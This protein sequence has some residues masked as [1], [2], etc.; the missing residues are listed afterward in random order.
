MSI[1]AFSAL[2]VAALCAMAGS[3]A[4]FAGGQRLA[5]VSITKESLH[6]TAVKVTARFAADE[7]GSVRGFSF[8]DEHAGIKGLSARVTELRTFDRY[9]SEIPNRRG[10]GGTV[11]A[12]APVYAVTYAV[13]IETRSD[14]TLGAH[15]SWFACGDGALMMYDLLPVSK[16]AGPPVKVTIDTARSAL[17]ISSVYTPEK[18]GAFLVTDVDN[19]VFVL[20]ATARNLSASAEGADLSFSVIGSWQYTDEDLVSMTREILAEYKRIFGLVPFR[21]IHLSIM[22]IGC[23]DLRDRWRAETRGPS[24]L[25]LSSPSTYRNHGAQL[26]HEQLR[27]ELLHLWIPNALRL[28]GDYSWFY[29]GFTF[30]RALIAGASLGRIRFEDVL[31]ALADSYR[32]AGSSGRWY[33]VGESGGIPLSSPG[34]VQYSQAVLL[35]FAADVAMMDGSGKNVDD[36]LRKVFREGTRLPV[37]EDAGE[38][39]I[40][41][42]AEYGPLI[43]IIGNHIRGTLPP[44]WAAFFQKAGL[45]K[46]PAAAGIRLSVVETPD[47][48]QRAMLRR[49]GY[50]DRR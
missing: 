31:D 4:S 32:R 41:K 34:G 9:G 5:E 30:Y 14:A 29:E 45:K 42:M 27:H 37:D 18:D 1:I 44:D 36:L 47:R 28:R 22:K 7:A 8:V 25:I 19:A 15:V 16:E 40:S 6:G 26:I 48:R 50:N 21:R 23:E 35:A 13:D 43:P 33:N 12:D 46:E 20:S 38:F 17:K 11:F 24:V 2:R 3:L 49:L 39:V 10:E